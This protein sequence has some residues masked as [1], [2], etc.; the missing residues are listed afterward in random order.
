MENESEVWFAMRITYRREK[1]AVALLEQQGLK[2]FLPMRYGVKMVKE[3]RVRT[4]VPVIYGLI[5]V[6]ALPETVKKVKSKAAYLQYVV[7][8]QSREKIIVPDDQMRRFMA[9]AG[10]YD[11]S[12]MWFTPDDLNLKKGTK[13]RIVGGE[14]EGWEGVF[15][16][17]KGA[18]DKRVVIEITG[19]V[20]VA[21]A[22]IHPDFIEVI[23]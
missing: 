14:F 21:M 1:Q 20:A 4:L 11:E 16:K 3:K 8:S 6:H 5:F 10:T 7:N 17:V 13:V 23:E 18:R 2:Y 12:L 9:V 19:V 15:M 22:S